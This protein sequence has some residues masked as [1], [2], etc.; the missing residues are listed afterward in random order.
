MNYKIIIIIIC[1][2]LISCDPADFN[3]GACTEIF[4]MINAEIIDAGNEEKIEGAYWKS[5]LKGS[6]SIIQELPEDWLLSQVNSDSPYLIASDNLLT[7][8][9]EGNK[10]VSTTVKKTGYQQINRDITLTVDD[11]DNPCH[12]QLEQGDTIFRLQ[13]IY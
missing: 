6:S 11:K 2:F 7:E 4:A 8:L 3:E 12:I 1:F 9:K 10:V 13:S 5:E